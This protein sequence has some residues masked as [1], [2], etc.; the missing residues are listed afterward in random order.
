MVEEAFAPLVRLHPA[1]NE[2]IPVAVRRWRADAAAAVD[3]AR[4][5]VA[6]AVRRALEARLRRDRRHAG[7]G[8]SRR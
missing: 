8:L 6:V 3:L 7:S 2:V 5:S 1:V 4:A